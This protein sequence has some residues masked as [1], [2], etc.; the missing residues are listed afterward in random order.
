MLSLRNNEILV[1]FVSKNKVFKVL[2]FFDDLKDFKIF[3]MV[4]KVVFRLSLMSESIFK[5]NK[6][7]RFLLIFGPKKI[8]F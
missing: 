2:V 3:F 4:G 7:F 1:I 5:K 6:K 8:F